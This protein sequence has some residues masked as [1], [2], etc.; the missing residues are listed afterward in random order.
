[1]PAG[2]SLTEEQMVIVRGWTAALL[3]KHGGSQT[4]AAKAIGVNQSTLSS[5]TGGK[6]GTGLPR[7]R[8][9]TETALR[10][11]DAIGLSRADAL[12][13]IGYLKDEESGA[14]DLPGGANRQAAEKSLR[15]LG[16]AFLDVRASADEVALLLKPGE[17]PDPND[18]WFD[19]IRIELRKRGASPKIPSSPPPPPSTTVKELST[20]ETWPGW[21]R[22]L[23]QFF[24]ELA[25]DELNSIGVA[26]I[27][28]GKTPTADEQPEPFD[29]ARLRNFAQQLYEARPRH[30]Q[31]DKRWMA[32][33]AEA[34]RVYDAENMHPKRR[35]AT[36]PRKREDC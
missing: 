35:S 24:R 21:K 19:L 30:S 23:Q 31:R 2:K 34:Q 36:G 5:I 22:A 18:W 10:I 9:T 15:S 11:A 25:G 3:A 13:E 1:M 17:D 4:E 28:F 8:T 14:G 7:Q 12:E 6:E 29:S 33:R 27:G 20:P 16:Y 26:A 32:W